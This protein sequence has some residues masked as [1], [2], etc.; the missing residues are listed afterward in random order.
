MFTIDFSK[1]PMVTMFPFSATTFIRTTRSL[2][3]KG[4]KMEHTF[5]TT[6]ITYIFESTAATGVLTLEVKKK[7]KK[8]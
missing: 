7:C 2:Y 5:N 1:I 8:L 3:V 6:Y 4:L